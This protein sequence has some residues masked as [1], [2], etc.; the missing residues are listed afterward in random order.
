MRLPTGISFGLAA[1]RGND[2]PGLVI[3]TTTVAFL[4]AIDKKPGQA[5]VRMRGERDRSPTSRAAYS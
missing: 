5:T 2:P 4:V 3:A 1:P